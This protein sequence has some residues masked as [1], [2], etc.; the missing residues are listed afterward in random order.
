MITKE[1]NKILVH[2]ILPEH[3]AQLYLSRQFRNDFYNEEYDNVAV[4]F[5]TIMNFES[6]ANTIESENNELRNLNE[7]I[8]AFDEKLL[9]FSGNL[10]IE[11]IKVAGY[12]YMCACGL[13]PGRGDST[14]SYTGLIDGR[15][16]LNSRNLPKSRTNK[17]SLRQSNNATI[18]LVEFAL[19]LM[20]AL[21]TISEINAN[22]RHLQLRVG[23]SFGKVMAGVVGLSKPL[24][25]IW[26]NSVNLASRMDSTGVP[27]KIQVIAKPVKSK[28][29]TM[30]HTP[31]MWVHSPFL[32]F[33]QVTEETANVLTSFGIK[34][35]FRGEVNVK[36]KGLLPTFFV[37]TTDNFEFERENLMTT[38]SSFES[39]IWK[40]A[41]IAQ[42]IWYVIINDREI[43]FAML[44]S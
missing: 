44:R 24:Y 36:G 6:A 2:N 20:R 43:K 5:A 29:F 16:S 17:V 40:P 41:I 3:V 19:E 30:F 13:D 7:I 15:R 4:M 37:S 8:C 21:R 1:T 28:K 9:T 18:N 32:S 22:F 35:S 39:H 31:H 34:C 25:D 26:G 12:S 11:K 38:S 23:I 10:K 33:S 14:G 27:G 42:L